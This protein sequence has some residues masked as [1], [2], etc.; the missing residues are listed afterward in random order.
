MW[1]NKNNGKGFTLIELIIVV[2]IIGF[3]AVLAI[4][5]LTSAT[6]RSRDSKRVADINSMKK[7][8]DI[9]NGEVGSFPDISSTTDWIT[10]FGAE[11]EE[12]ISPFPVD[13]EHSDGS[14][15]VYLVN[16]GHDEYYLKAILENSGHQA[17][18]QDIDG[19][20]GDP[21]G[22]ESLTSANTF[23]PTSGD[24]RINCNDSSFCVNGFSQE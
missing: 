11:L 12:Y 13:P 6:Q 22:W 15:Y 14:V 3:L 19:I 24:A 9:Y 18:T 17:L 16:G 2:A 5:V 20:V 21:N 23:I 10:G 4:V 8:L 1:K 7:A